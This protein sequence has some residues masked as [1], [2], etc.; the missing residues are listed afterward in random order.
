MN[1]IGDLI[2][3]LKESGVSCVWMNMMCK[4]SNQEGLAALK[5]LPIREDVVAQ[6][7]LSV[8]GEIR[9]YLSG[10]DTEEG[11]ASILKEGHEFLDATFDLVKDKGVR[12]EAVCIPISY[13][14]MAEQAG[15]VQIKDGMVSLTEQ[16][17]A[18]AKD[19]K[20][21]ITTS[22]IGEKGIVQNGETE[23]GE[24]GGIIR[25]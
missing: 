19:L 12:K 24:D 11:F 22:P 25:I 23:D 14:E 16:G 18:M 1:T 9:S 5:S 20:D 10:V 2:I 15:V 4:H 8:V 21:E 7:C 17:A 3:S 6:F 13:A